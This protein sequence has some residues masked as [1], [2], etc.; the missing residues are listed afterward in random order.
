MIPFPDFYIKRLTGDR[1][2]VHNLADRYVVYWKDYTTGWA[3]A[4]YTNISYRRAR[5]EAFYLQNNAV[6]FDSLRRYHRDHLHVHAHP[7]FFKVSL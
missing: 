2:A 5:A 7:D 3:R 1:A 6:S 4:V